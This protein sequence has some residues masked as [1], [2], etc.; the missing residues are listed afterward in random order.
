LKDCCP[1]IVLAFISVKITAGAV[2]IPGVPV[3]S[4]VYVFPEIV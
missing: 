3:T 2:S 1:S 4:S